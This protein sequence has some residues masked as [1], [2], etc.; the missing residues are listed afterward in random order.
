MLNGFAKHRPLSTIEFEQQLDYI[1]QWMEKWNDQVRRDLIELLLPRCNP[2]Q[3]TFLWT[4]V[5]PT[6]HRDFM[7]SSLNA[8]PRSSFS[9][10]ST[11]LCSEVHKKLGKPRYRAWK[12]HRVQ[13]AILHDESTYFGVKLPGI[14]TVTSQSKTL[15]RFA[16]SRSAPPGGATKT[17][18]QHAVRRHMQNEDKKDFPKNCFPS[19]GAKTEDVPTW[20]AEKRISSNLSSSSRTQRIVKQYRDFIALLPEPLALHILSFLVP[21]EL[22]FVCQ[23]SKTWRRLA[24]RDELWQSKCKETY[25]GVPLSVPA[26]WK[27]IFRENLNL[28]RNW[29]NGRCKVMDMCAFCLWLQELHRYRK[30][31]PDNKS[32]GCKHRDFDPNLYGPHAWNL[33]HSLSF[34][35]YYNKWIIR[36]NNS[37][38]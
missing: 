11:P 37:E 27:E 20:L 5:E 19:S 32:L 35:E 23:V 30:L 36:Q 4:V 28:K 6:L 29:A 10:V 33:E 26:V 31:G 34:K 14:S 17:A 25:V 7:Y 12:L 18:C 8:F 15:P 16:A 21:K 9:T 22:L 3:I 2:K 38:Y 24:S 13:S 1:C